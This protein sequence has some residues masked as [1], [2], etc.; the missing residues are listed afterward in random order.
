MMRAQINLTRL[1]GVDKEDG[2]VALWATLMRHVSALGQIHGKTQVHRNS[3]ICFSSPRATV[4]EKGLDR[5]APGSGPGVLTCFFSS[6]FST[7]CSVV[8]RGDEV[9]SI[10]RNHKSSSEEFSILLI[11]P[12]GS[13]PTCDNR[14]RELDAWYQQVLNAKFPNMHSSILTQVRPKIERI[15]RSAALG[16][17]KP[18]RR[19]ELILRMRKEGFFGLLDM[20]LDR[21]K[22]LV[23]LGL[24]GNQAVPPTR[25]EALAAIGETA[26][27]LL[28]EILEGRPIASF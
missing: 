11:S 13:F 21:L 3:R 1:P 7:Q 25:V 5:I 2:A 19:A 18:A 10:R 24:P 28:V 15:Y 27:L 8:T 23:A 12:L 26:G 14:L 6:G 20:D 4:I 16:E 22:D 17:V 9:V